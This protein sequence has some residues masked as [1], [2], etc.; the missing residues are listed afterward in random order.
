MSLKSVPHLVSDGVCSASLAHS[1]LADLG[2]G[3]GTRGS[4][5]RVCPRVSDHDGGGRML[6]GNAVTGFL[7]TL[8][9]LFP[10]ARATDLEGPLG[11]VGGHAGGVPEACLGA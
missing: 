7:I 8:L 2:A 10:G 3:S 9:A 6:D 11:Y 4:R 1:I 5:F